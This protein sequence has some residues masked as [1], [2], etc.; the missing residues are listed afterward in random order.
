MEKK[1]AKQ[2]FLI[3]PKD[4]I[5]K[6]I[7]KALSQDKLAYIKWVVDEYNKDLEPGEAK[8]TVVEWINIQG[9]DVDVCGHGC[10]DCDSRIVVGDDEHCSQGEEMK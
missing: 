6:E 2:E 8:I 1:R 4:M 5:Q 10:K 7:R 9:V 3:T